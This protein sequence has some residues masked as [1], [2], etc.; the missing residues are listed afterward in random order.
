MIE[1]PVDVLKHR[2]TVFLKSLYDNVG[3]N[4]AASEYIAAYDSLIKSD[5]YFKP[6]YNESQLLTIAKQ[7]DLQFGTDTQYTGDVRAIQTSN[8]PN[9]QSSIQDN[10]Y[11]QP[12]NNPLMDNRAHTFSDGVPRLIPA[13][14]GTMLNYH[15]VSDQDTFHAGMSRAQYDSGRIM[16]WHKD[17][18]QRSTQNVALQEGSLNNLTQEHM[19][20]HRLLNMQNGLTPEQNAEK[21]VAEWVKGD[22][23]FQDYLHGLEGYSKAERDKI[24]QDIQEK[25]YDHS[26]DDGLMDN[27]RFNLGL[28]LKPLL[29]H[30]TKSSSHP[31]H[32]IHVSPENVGVNPPEAKPVV[33]D[34]LDPNE[35]IY[36]NRSI[37]HHLG[38]YEQNKPRIERVANIIMENN[39]QK[40][41]DEAYNDAMHQDFY[42]YDLFKYNDRT[43]KFSMDLLPKQASHEDWE[44]SVNPRN[45]S[46]SGFFAA[47]NY[48]PDKRLFYDEFNPSPVKG[49]QPSKGVREYFNKYKIPDYITNFTNSKSAIY[50][51]THI[52]NHAIPWMNRR[53]NIKNAGDFMEGD[54]RG[55]NDLFS[56]PFQK[57]GGHH[58]R[59]NNALRAIA[60]LF[61]RDGENTMFDIESPDTENPLVSIPDEGMYYIGPKETYYTESSG[62]LF[63]QKPKTSSSKAMAWAGQPHLTRF[64]YKTFEDDEI[65]E[66]HKNVEEYNKLSDEDKRYAAK[67]QL[68]KPKS[69]RIR[70]MYDIPKPRLFYDN[71]GNL[72]PESKRKDARYR[73]RVEMRDRT[74]D[75]S[76]HLSQYNR[77]YRGFKAGTG[78]LDKSL[79]GYTHSVDATH[80]HIDSHLDTM[81]EAYDDIDDTSRRWLS[82]QSSQEKEYE[83][84]EGTYQDVG[85]N[86]H[87]KEMSRVNVQERAQYKKN[88]ADY[89]KHQMT[90]GANH[91]YNPQKTNVLGMSESEPFHEYV[92]KLFN[93]TYTRDQIPNIKEIKEELDKKTKQ[94]ETLGLGLKEREANL[95][96]ISANRYDYDNNEDFFDAVNQ[97]MKL[98]N[99]IKQQQKA[100][101]DAIK[102]MNVARQLHTKVQK[103]PRM[104]KRQ[105][106]N[107]LNDIIDLEEFEKYSGESQSDEINQHKENIDD[108]LKRLRPYVGGYQPKKDEHFMK[109]LHHDVEAIGNKAQSL[110]TMAENMGVD[111]GDKSSLFTL[112]SNAFVLARVAEQELH[113]HGGGDDYFTYNSVVEDGVSKNKLVPIKDVS[114]RGG[115]GINC[116]FT[117]PNPHFKWHGFRPTIKPIYDSNHKLIGFQ[118]VPEYKYSSRTM[119]MSMYEK[120]M[121]EYVQMY[122]SSFGKHNRGGFDMPK[123]F[124]KLFKKQETLDAPILLASL[125]NPDILL[126]EDAK[127][128]ILQPMHRIFKL[129]DLEHLR[130]FT[131]D[132]IVS[133]MPEGPRAFVQSYKDKVTTRGEFELDEDTKKNFSKISKKNYVVDVALSNGEYHVL[134]I[135]EYDDKEVH[136][137]PLQERIKILRGT[138]ESTENVLLPAAHNLRLTDDIGLEAV[139]NE[140]KKEHT[141]LVLRDANSTYMKGEP[142][143]P[144]WV[145]LDA[146]NDVNLMVL[147][148]KGTSSYTYRLGTGPITHEDSLGSRAVKHNGDTYMDVGTTF[149]SKEKYE[150]G[151]IVT[152]NVDSISVTENIEGSDIYTVNGTEIQGEAEGEGVSSVETLSLFAKSDPVMWPHEIDRDGDRIVIKMPAGEV[153]Y[154]ASV[155]DNGWYMFNPKA[156]NEWL[157]RLAET[158][159]PFWSS[160]AG[161]MLKAD[162]S[163]MDEESKAEVHESKN[164]GKPLIPPKKTKGTNFWNSKVDEALAEK[165]KVR[166]LLAKSLNLVEIM[167]KSGVGAVGN[168]STGVMGLG[169]DYATPIESPTGPTNLN[170]AKTM[171]DYDGRKREGEETDVKDAKHHKRIDG[172]E[173]LDDLGHLSIDSESAT[174]VSS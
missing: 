48:N 37:Y 15:K 130:G 171:P 95:S 35:L 112:F 59:L 21:H 110:R 43:K 71:F 79:K 128:P 85:D 140:L 53:I 151:D 117:D 13:W 143:H 102:E 152:V 129:E 121:P 60:P 88:V 80:H 120:I 49:Y 125:S 63:D 94:A 77:G 132:W 32:N 107:A 20:H 78:G 154:R 149:Q 162:L 57:H 86:A 5:I 100:Y 93:L 131:G 137:M 50:T 90:G 118:N 122:G 147:D 22:F 98:Q 103:T 9:P 113:S 159:R 62:S 116:L 157:I 36:L 61:H 54:E 141:R 168:S 70:S 8:L 55:F 126:K 74:L 6:V 52:R 58:L 83:T 136:D 142:R 89:R 44:H 144:K 65:E 124:N 46:V 138:M 39:P 169:I 111:M 84:I 38:L 109:K 24:Y 64:F 7:E 96:S 56:A 163:V 82:G 123:A 134:D 156:E 16:G 73:A 34:Y 68:P 25:G 51:G 87:R 160:V 174:F 119:P 42:R 150:V 97:R 106:T 40:T 91:P 23:T 72:T 166:R 1:T 75:L 105:L 92:S 33:Y 104:T 114:K 145:L 164:D 26:T 133:A 30:L 47:T 167:L 11:M 69:I 76:S 165:D 66:Y 10:F 45:I 2:R 99:E 155:M 139:V 12:E 127:Y 161:V 173:L 14:L 67:P 19:P 148:R 172:K 108:E 28:R 170:D 4:E 101:G 158:Q 3:T 81:R 153:S 18:K 27:I 146:G 115:H 135:V 29:D 41:Y 31:S 17:G